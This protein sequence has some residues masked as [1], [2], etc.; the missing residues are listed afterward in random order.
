M[1]VLVREAIRFLDGRWVWLWLR[2]AG[3][4]LHDVIRVKVDSESFLLERPGH[5]AVPLDFHRVVL[6]EADRHAQA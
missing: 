2:G 5:A 3:E 4:P 1:S 6:W